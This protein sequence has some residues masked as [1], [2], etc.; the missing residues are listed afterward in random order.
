MS[1]ERSDPQPS[2]ARPGLA[3][4]AAPRCQGFKAAAAEGGRQ[5]HLSPPH[6]E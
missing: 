2:A 1:W 3:L 5:L 6:R 4:G